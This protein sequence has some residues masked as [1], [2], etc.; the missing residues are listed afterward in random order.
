[1]KQFK[2]IFKFETASKFKQ[3]SFIASLIIVFII[4]LG[5]T[6]VPMI[7]DA[8]NIGGSGHGGNGTG[9]SESTESGSKQKI[10]LYVKGDVNKELP[11]L[12]KKR[13]KVL[14]VDSVKELKHMVTSK[15]V[16][17]SVLLE[18]PL[19]AKIFR[20]ADNAFSFANA[21]D[22]ISMLLK[23]NYKY[24]IGFKNMGAD[25][26]KIQKIE[27][28]TPEVGIDVIG[29]NPLASVAF[30]YVGIFFLYFLILMLGGGIAMTVCREKESRT[31]ELLVTNV[32]SKSLIWGKVLSGV[33]LGF[34]QCGVM[35]GSA[36]IG[37]LINSFISK[38]LNPMLNAIID[39]I[40]PIDVLVFFVLAADDEHF[41]SGEQYYESGI[42]YTVF[43]TVGNVRKIYNERR[44]PVGAG[45]KYSYTCC[46]DDSHKPDMYKDI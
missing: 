14:N 39:S 18:D 32:S 38:D 19:K 16:E 30:A 35:V 33:F 4:C 13:Y 21:E 27:N 43:I 42:L 7:L 9:G 22:D 10:A 34:V 23:E 1:M 2:E 24:N 26:A 45:F 31:M 12:L 37:L 17:K 29:K 15:K 8:M 40:N 28:V 46:Y 6:F 5:L 25:I 3:K 41:R 20:K 44:K 11:E 36:G